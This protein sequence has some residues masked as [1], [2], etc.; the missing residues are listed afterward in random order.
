VS[1]PL[2]LAPGIEPY[3]GHNLTSFLGRGA[4]GEVWQAQG[5]EGKQL[6]LKFLPC[7]NQLHAAHEIRALQSIRQLRHPNLIGVEQI[8]C[9]SGYIVVAMELADGSLLDLLEIYK[10]DFETCIVPDHLCH[11]LGQAA[12]AIDFLNARQHALGDQRVAV[13]HCDIKPSNM[14]VLQT[15]VKVADFSLAMQTTSPMSYHRRAGT[16]HYAAPE[17]FQGW[18]SDRTDQYALA[19]S[20]IELRTGYLPFTDTPLTFLTDYTRPEPDL[21]RL[22]PW[23]RPVLHRALHPVPQDRWPSCHDMVQQLR[24]RMPGKERNPK[25]QAPNPKQSQMTEVQDPKPQG[26]PL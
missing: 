24:Q 8:W 23:E 4:L 1:Q 6:A 9:W 7:D 2:M 10:A 20:Y 16:L 12:D 5:P 15:Q 3:P 13:R 18:L 14:L 22:D 26:L 11:F 17:V 21:S 19:V 25:S